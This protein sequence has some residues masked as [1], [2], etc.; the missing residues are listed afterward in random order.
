MAKGGLDRKKIKNFKSVEFPPINLK[1]GHDDE[2]VAKTLP[3]DPLH[4]NLLGPCNDALEILEEEFKIE[5]KFFYAKHCL[6]KTGES[7]GGKFNGP[8]IKTVL[9][10]LDDLA[11][12]LPESASS[13]IDYFE[14]INSLHK[15]CTEETLNE[16]FKEIIKNFT[17]AFEVVHQLFNLS[18]P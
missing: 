4:T 12:E 7:A 17:E 5:M 16:N 3:P 11:E 14:S 8:S 1:H 6:N 15:M 18:Q 9:K 13:F 10:N 2:W